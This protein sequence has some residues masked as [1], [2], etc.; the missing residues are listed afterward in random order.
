M[1]GTPGLPSG[2]W[3]G[4]SECLYLGHPCSRLP[5]TYPFLTCGVGASERGLAGGRVRDQ[6]SKQHPLLTEPVPRAFL[7]MGEDTKNNIITAEGIIL[8]FCAVVPGTL[9]LFRVSRPGPAPWS[10]RVPTQNPGE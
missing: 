8:L 4:A 10:R 5:H 2:K 6:G 1:P 7:D 3:E 9:L